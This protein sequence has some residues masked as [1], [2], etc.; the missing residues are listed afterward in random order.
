[1]SAMRRTP[2]LAVLG[3]G[4]AL[5]AGCGSRREEP[6]PVP[7]AA[8]TVTAEDGVPI[9]YDVRGAGDPAVVLVHGW[10]CNREFWRNQADLLAADHRVVAIDLPG[11]G[12]SGAD[13]AAWSIA[14]L[15]ADV[16]TVVESLGLGRVILVGH[17]LGGPVALEAARLLPGRTVAVIAVDTLHDAD[18]ELP[19]DAMETMAARF[20]ED[21]SGT[22]AQAV[23][24]MFTESADPAVVEWVISASLATNRAAALALM[25]DYPA[26]RPKQALAA[27]G[28]PIRCIN[29][30]PREGAGGLPTDT[31]GNRRFADYDAVVMEGVG[32]FPMLERPEEFNAELRKVLA[33][34]PSS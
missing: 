26:F 30:A 15:G 19:P 24:S 7:P 12:A 10:C 34:L 13:R 23:R 14:G 31:E 16:R 4:L 18:F 33:A 20:E 2:R 3:A 9:A 32:H 5:L 11:H 28:V 29:V 8:G 27:A 22:M 21:F 1:M 17:S 25:R 6:A